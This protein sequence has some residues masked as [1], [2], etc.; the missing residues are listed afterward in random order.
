MLLKKKIFWICQLSGWGIVG[1]INLFVK[2]FFGRSDGLIELISSFL[3]IIFGILCSYLLRCVFK[4]LNLIERKPLSVIVWVIFLST[5]A[6][7]SM[8]ICMLISLSIYLMLIGKSID[9]FTVETMVGNSIGLYPILFS[10]CCLYFCV[11]Y[12]IRW[13]KNQLDKISLENTLKSAQLNVLMGQINPHFIFNS[14]NNIR[15]LMLEDV[16]RSR[17][18]ITFL[19]KVLRYSLTSEHRSLIE[20]D[21]ELEVVSDFIELAKIQYE[22]RLD[23]S[24][25]VQLDSDDIKIPPM[26][27][28]IL[29]ENAVKHG[30]ST[31]EGGGKLTLSI[32]EQNCT[33]IIKVSN[34][35]KITSTHMYPEE[36]VNIGV[37][38]INIRRRLDLL[39]G[40]TAKFELV[41]H[42]LEC[43]VEA[44]ITLPITTGEG[45]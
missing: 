31:V 38:V 35:G 3:I 5:V 9:L 26:I 30:I 23:F 24:S 2:V 25:K 8:V 15:A 41:E 37:G 18:M 29:I 45:G 40:D 21:K 6:M 36:R 32:I 44:S 22:E 17:D 42:P 16:G 43:R 1:L 28:Q 39:Y 27:I 4:K 34:P 7:L 20:I 13:N 10:W 14:L 19:A 12:L 11:S 33:L